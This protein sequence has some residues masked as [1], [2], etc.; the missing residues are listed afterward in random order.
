MGPSSG[1]YYDLKEGDHVVWLRTGAY[2]EYSTAAAVKTIVIPDGLEPGQAAAALLQ[3]LTAL[4]MI[5]ESYAV[6]TGDWILVHAAAGGVGLWLCQLLKSVGAR[7]IGTTSGGG[8]GELARE[9]GAEF[10]IDSKTENVVDRV[11]DIT[12]GEG[13]NAVFD[14][15]SLEL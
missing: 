6:K 5:R 7:I 4:T 11:L 13:V 3:G 14:G 2:A 10:L 8:K 12:S 1:Q 9:F 15:V